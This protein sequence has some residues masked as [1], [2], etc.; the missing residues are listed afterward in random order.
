MAIVIVMMVASSGG[1]VKVTRSIFLELRRAETGW[2]WVGR[3][4]WA[5]PP[6]PLHL[7]TT[8]TC[9]LDNWGKGSAVFSHCS[10]VIKTSRDRVQFVPISLAGVL[11]RL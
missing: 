1:P 7:G 4:G 5:R 2:H 11:R 6:P 8:L 9:T 3:A 10:R